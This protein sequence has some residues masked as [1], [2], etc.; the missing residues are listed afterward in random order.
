M[1][2]LMSWALF[3]GELVFWFELPLFPQVSL[4][5]LLRRSGSDLLVLKSDANTPPCSL[6]LERFPFSVLGVES[7]VG[8][9]LF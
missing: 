4:Q 2:K 8:L 3:D 5:K 9:G 7:A 6:A 1:S